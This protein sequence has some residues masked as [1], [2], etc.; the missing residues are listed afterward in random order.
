MHFRT[1]QTSAFSKWQFKW[2]ISNLARWC[3]PLNFTLLCRFRRPWSNPKVKAASERWT[4][5]ISFSWRVLIPEVKFKRFM[6]VVYYVAFPRWNCLIV[7]NSACMLCAS[8]PKIIYPERTKKWRR[9]VFIRNAGLQYMRSTCWGL[10]F[11]SSEILGSGIFSSEILDTGI[12]H[13]ICW[14]LVFSIRN[15]ESLYTHPLRT[16]E[17]YLR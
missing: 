15:I 6:V 4:T 11:F 7:S 2:D 8:Q 10:V 16:K 14:P 5:K 17:Y 12:F 3:L 9:H 13:Q 1:L